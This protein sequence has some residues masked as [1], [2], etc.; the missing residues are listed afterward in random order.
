MGTTC[1]AAT[2]TYSRHVIS[3]NQWGGQGV[4]CLNQFSGPAGWLASTVM[5]PTQGPRKKQQWNIS[6]Y[7][8]AQDEIRSRVAC[9]RWSCV[10]GDGLISGADFIWGRSVGLALAASA[11]PSSSSCIRCPC[12]PLA[13]GTYLTVYRGE[14]WSSAH[15]SSRPIDQSSSK[16]VW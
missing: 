9:R 3:S 10:R 1:F 13:A 8:E 7:F 12:A 5:T 2:V 4:A 16:K 11:R 14:M 6:R 15:T